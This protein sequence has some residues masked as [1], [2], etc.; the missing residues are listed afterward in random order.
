MSYDNWIRARGRAKVYSEWIHVDEQKPKDYETIWVR[1]DRGDLKAVYKN[2]K[3]YCETD[4][5]QLNNVE[6]WQRLQ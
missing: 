1:S 6:L 5:V 4:F 2:S 3:F